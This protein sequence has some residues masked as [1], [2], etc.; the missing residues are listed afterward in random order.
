VAFKAAT[1]SIAMEERKEIL[2]R[3][4]LLVKEDGSLGLRSSDELKDLIFHHFGF[5][6][7]ELTVYRSY[8]APF[9]IFFPDRHARDVVYGAGRIIDGS[10]LV[11]GILMSSETEISS[12]TMSN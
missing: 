5:H 9:L 1:S 10:V 6:K 2:S 3:L 4:A 12:L 11:P 7:H 8:P